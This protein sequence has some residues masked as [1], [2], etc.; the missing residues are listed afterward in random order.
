MQVEDIK[1]GDLKFDGENARKHS[2]RN[3]KA[4]VDSLKRFGQ[5]KPI[6]INSENTV[7]AG[8]G[9]LIGAQEL[10]WK[11]IACVRSELSGQ[12]LSAFAIAD[13]R[14]AELAEW[15]MAILVEQLKEL[16]EADTELLY[17]S[18]WNEGEL[19]AMLANPSD[20]DA[21]DAEAEWQNMPEFQQEKLAHRTIIVHC[22]CEEDF[23][24]F[25]KLMKQPIGEKTKF[26]WYPQADR[27]DT[28]PLRY[29]AEETKA[30]PEPKAE[31]KT[32]VKNGAKAK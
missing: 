12:E 24:K 17:A 22:T 26:I 18:G 13:N 16:D 29:S 2:K 31:L 32:K 10:G 8:N 6:V 30:E 1:I 14:T 21:N 9:T 11:T 25:T 23:A 5:Q 15:D 3:L 19:A 20:G 28:A 4:I 27:A 7:K